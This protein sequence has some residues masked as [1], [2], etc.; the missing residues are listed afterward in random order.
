[1]RGFALVVLFCLTSAGQ[2]LAGVADLT[3]TKVY[4]LELEDQVLSAASSTVTVKPGANWAKVDVFIEF[5]FTNATTLTLTPWCSRDG[6]TYSA[7]AATAI[8]GAAGTASVPYAVTTSSLTADLNFKISFD[9]RGCEG[10]R[11]TVT[12]VGGLAA[13]KFSLSL[14]FTTG[15]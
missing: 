3:Q 10:W 15:T 12:D 2:A 1:M 9:A 13:D 14:V 8:S 11:V 7:Y 4:A 6:S 5:D